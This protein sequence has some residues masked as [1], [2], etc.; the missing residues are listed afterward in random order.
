MLLI[1]RDVRKIALLDALIPGLSVPRSDLPAEEIALR[2][3]HFAINRLTDLPEI[4]ISKREEAFLTWLFRA[5]AVRASAIA[6]EDIAFYARQLAGPGILRAAGA[7]YREAF[8]SEGLAANRKRGETKLA[9]PVM[10]L[11]AERGVGVTMLQALI[12]VGDDVS[13]GVIEGAGH[14]LPEE[15]GPRVSRELLKFYDAP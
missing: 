6:P 9:M 1:G 15:V 7:Y 2:S 10:A 11:G 5:K 14:Y 13:G 3:W 8:S 4:L 12:S